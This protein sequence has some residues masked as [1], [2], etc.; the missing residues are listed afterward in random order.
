MGL[1]VSTYGE[2]DV[3]QSI[4]TGYCNPRDLW[5]P[6]DSRRAFVPS[7]GP[8]SSPV[9]NFSGKHVVSEGIY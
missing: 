7:R 5:D 4:R 8:R 6:W 2:R 3:L 1:G 9:L